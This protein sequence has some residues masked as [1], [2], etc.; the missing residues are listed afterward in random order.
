MYLPIVTIAAKNMAQLKN[1]V[2]SQI[3]KYTCRRQATYNN[4]IN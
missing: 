2:Y 3:L 4:L 1:S